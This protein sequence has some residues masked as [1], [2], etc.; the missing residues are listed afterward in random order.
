MLKDC[1]VEPSLK[2]A[3]VG[4]SFQFIRDGYFTLDPDSADGALVF[5]RT[6]QLNSSY[7]K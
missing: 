6:V 3:K 7:K 4:E 2:D 5:N 1:L